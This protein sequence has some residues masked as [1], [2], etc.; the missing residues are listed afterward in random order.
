MNEVF[1]ELG[2]IGIVPVI[3]IDDVEKAVP[4]A[5]ALTAGGIPCAEITF[6]T[7]Q[8]EEALR[9]IGRECPEILP[10]AGTV[11]TPG[12]VDRAV[13]AGA[14]FIASPGFN[15]KVVAHCI[16]RGIPIVP[17]CSNPSDIEQA[18]EAGL[19]AVKFFPAESAGGLP[20][21]KAVAAPYP[22]LK[23][24]P[25]GGI[26]ADNI[27]TYLSYEKIFACGGSWMVDASLINA[28]RFDE[29]T[30]RCREA[31]QKAHG[32]SMA[33]IGINT[34]NEDEAR[35]AAAFLERVFGFAPR[36]GGSSIFAGDGIEIVKFPRPGRNGHIAVA[37][38]NVPRAKAYLERNGLDF[39]RESAHPDGK[40]GLSAIYLSG[41][42]A[43][44]AVHLVQKK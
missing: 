34:A 40:G 17:G 32:F 42:V 1:E 15:P 16:R 27:G 12:Q 41:E 14:R 9:R 29:I 11:L 44:F 21:I 36:D 19:D 7:E 20:Y 2:N 6:R 38:N 18:L 30:R 8:G 35:K 39:N 37:V 4:L 5:R 13:E 25:T 23:F 28:A 24:M 31:L 22:G 33:H 10:G 3:T 26:N 43:G